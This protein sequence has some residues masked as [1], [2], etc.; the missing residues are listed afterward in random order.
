MACKQHRYL[1]LIA[2]RLEKGPVAHP[3]FSWVSP[4]LV[5]WVLEFTEGWARSK[6]TSD[7]VPAYFYLGISFKLFIPVFSSVKLG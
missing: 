2:D 6:E 3:C 1:N 5:P 4:T 7:L